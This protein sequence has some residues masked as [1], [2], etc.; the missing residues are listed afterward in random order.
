MRPPSREPTGSKLRAVVVSAH[1]PAMSSG[2]T[3]TSRAALRSTLSTSCV[4]L[5]RS[6]EPCRREEG[7]LTRSAA[8]PVAESARP[9]MKM[10]RATAPPASGPAAATSKSCVRV[11]IRDRIWV[12]EPKVPSWPLGM[13]KGTDSLTSRK[14]PMILCARSCAPAEASTPRVTGIAAL[15]YSTG[16]KF[17]SPG[18]T[19]PLSTLSG[20]LNQ[21]RVSEG[22]R[23]TSA[24]NPN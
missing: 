17:S 14:S 13:K 5:P 23:V 8:S 12:T 24:T 7:T 6:S 21:L 3:A 10:A 16:S 2:C 18:G 20:E 1:H 19:A 15:K 22:S 4:R 9:L 11:L